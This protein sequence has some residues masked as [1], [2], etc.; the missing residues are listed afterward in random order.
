MQYIWK[1]SFF[2]NSILEIQNLSGRILMLSLCLQRNWPWSWHQEIR[3]VYSLFWKHINVY[4]VKRNRLF[5]PIVVAVVQCVIKMFTQVK[6]NAFVERYGIVFLTD[7]FILRKSQTPL[8]YKAV[9]LAVAEDY[10][11]RSLLFDHF[12]GSE[13]NCVSWLDYIFICFRKK[14]SWQSCG[15]QART[16]NRRGFCRSDFLSCWPFWISS[17]Y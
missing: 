9:Q 8:F 13:K 3:E 11:K 15:V 16:R 2:L 10:I 7:L 1:C 5:G 4:S 17:P 14:P 6:L 12:S